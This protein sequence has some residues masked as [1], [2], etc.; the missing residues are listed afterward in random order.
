SLFKGGSRTWSLGAGVVQPVFNAGL[1]RNQVA[2]AEAIERGALYSY[3]RSII[4]G[5]HEV[6]D[7]LVDRAKLTQSRDE[8]AQ[9]VAAFGRFRDLAE[10][11]YR[12]GATIYLEVANAEN[13]L[14]DAELSLSDT[15][16]LLFQSYANLYKAMGGP[17]VTDAERQ[18]DVTQPRVQ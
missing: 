15:R 5:F 2:Q 18:A 11:R 6:E 14:F 16:A 13:L 3:Q 7:A 10:L 4:E 17:W 1:T 9:N 8:Q 12:E